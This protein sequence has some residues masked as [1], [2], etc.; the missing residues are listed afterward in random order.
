MLATDQVL[1]SRW[2]ANRDAQA[3]KTLTTQYCKIVY[4]TSLRIL[5]SASDA[6]EVT[7]DCFVALA[8]ARTGPQGSLGAWL[9]RVATYK[10]LN[11]R[12][13]DF[14]RRER[15]HAYAQARAT[16][17]EAQWD[18]I[19]QF[20]DQSIEAL[21]D[22]IRMAVVAH[23]IEDES[24]TSIASRECVTHGAISQ[25]IQRGVEMIRERMRRNGI[26]I[27]AAAIA[28]MLS[29]QASAWPAVPASLS[30]RLGKLALS[31]GTTASVAASA[32]SGAKALTCAAAALIVAGAVVV[33]ATVSRTEPIVKAAVTDP[34]AA[35]A[36]T[37]PVSAEPTSTAA[38]E[39]APA[40][41]TATAAPPAA[42]R[43]EAPEPSTW[44]EVVDAYKAHQDRIRRISFDYTNTT[45]G[46]YF[47]QSFSPQPGTHNYS[48]RGSFATDGER[49]ATKYYRWGQHF[50]ENVPANKPLYSV[51][52]YDSDT[53]VQFNGRGG[54]FDGGPGLLWIIPNA[55]DSELQQSAFSDG[56]VFLLHTAYPGAE[57]LGFPV[58]MCGLRMEE[59][60]YG[61]HQISLRPA[62]ETIGIM[63]CYVVDADTDYGVFTV[64]FSPDRDYNVAKS[65]IVLGPGDIYERSPLLPGTSA[66]FEYSANKFT[67][68]NGCWVPME[69]TSRDIARLLNHNGFDTTSLHKRSNIKLPAIGEDS[70]A[71][72]AN[73][74]DIPN[75]ARLMPNI[76]ESRASG[77]PEWI[78]QDGEFVLMADTPDAKPIRR[79]DAAGFG[80][81]ILT[82]PQ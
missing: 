82:D 51:Y 53:L 22:K 23:F 60:L 44:R 73:G 45:R 55:I 19:S 75:G 65:V 2:I 16:T 77:D 26:P 25:R 69:S 61:A 43:A 31:G 7:Q 12:R 14:R 49:C 32:W 1:L 27:G 42:V 9:H 63:E 80:G 46:P 30:A 74:E 28:A 21:P 52:A 62:K 38:S 40:S 71:Y 13:S 59:I 24:V 34:P 81:G 54:E 39:P 33:Y 20:I 56:R 66:Y 70:N 67:Q 78:W 76:G 37:A 68:V 3:F 10:A 79:S 4:G 47:Y 58:T 48:E 29:Q 15:E 5:R 11:R 57:M 72:A 41:S 64:W 35:V 6:E 18:D 36:V 8:T 50:A 17:T